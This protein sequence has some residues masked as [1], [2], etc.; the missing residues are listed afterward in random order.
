MEDALK[1][2]FN[3]QD[4][5]GNRALQGVIDSVHARYG[6]RELSLDEMEFVSAAGVPEIAK[7]KKDQEKGK[8][9]DSDH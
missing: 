5:D 9:D 4:F 2:L 1:R 7:A 3:F 6:M 8:N